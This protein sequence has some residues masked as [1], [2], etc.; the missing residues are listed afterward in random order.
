MAAGAVPGVVPPEVT[1]L[2]GGA[3]SDVFGTPGVTPPDVA[4]VPGVEPTEVLGA[5]ISGGVA[6]GPGAAA[7][8]WSE[9]ER[10]AAG[11]TRSRMTSSEH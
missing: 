9:D 3:P 11:P 10:T 7:G 4:A 6:A 1:G 5:P 8:G 2:P